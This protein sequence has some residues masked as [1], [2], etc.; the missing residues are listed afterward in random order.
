[1]GASAVRARILRE[2]WLEIESPKSPAPSPTPG[3]EP[4]HPT[5]DPSISCSARSATIRR[6]VG[7]SSARAASRASFRAI[8]KGWLKPAGRPCCARGARWTE[9]SSSSDWNWTV[10]FA[11]AGRVCGAGSLG[12]LTFGVPDALR[13]RRRSLGRTN[14]AVAL[15]VATERRG[16]GGPQAE[17][18]V[19]LE[20]SRQQRGH[21]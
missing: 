9:R 2:Q 15:A 5:G 16:D 11:Y 12:L 19:S 13:R 8:A 3:K 21:G 18:Q 4:S 7:G 14:P 20:S 10:T 17:R 6:R 1:M